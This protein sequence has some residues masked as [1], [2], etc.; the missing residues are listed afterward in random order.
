MN[1]YDVVIVG[2]GPG[3]YVAAIRSGQLGLR[4][5]LVERENVGGVCLNWGCVPTKALLRNA[6]VLNLFHRAKEFGIAVDSLQADYGKGVDRSRRVVKRLTTGVRA[7]LKK[8]GV[9]VIE[10]TGRLRSAD[11]LVVEP[12]GRSLR[13]ADII[14]A[15]GARP[16]ALPGIPVDGER[17]VTYRQ[18]IVDRSVP[19]S[20]V[21]VG[22]GPIGMEFAEVYHAYG[23]QV[24]VVEMLPHLLPLEDEEISETMERAFRKKGV[25]FRTGARVE[26]VVPEGDNLVVH[27]AG[28]AGDERLTVARVLVA[29]GIQ[30]NSEEIGLD[31]AGVQTE[32]GFIQ[33]NG[34][35]RT[36]V[37][38]VY[39][40]GDVTGKLPLAHVAMAQGVLAAEVIAGRSPVS[41]NYN[42]IPRCTYTSPQVASM[43][44]SEAQAREQGRDVAVGRFPFRA[45]GKALAL[46]DYEGFAKI[47]SD[48]HYGEILG[49]HLIGPEVTEMLPEFGLA[50]QLEAT[51]AEIARVVHAHPTLSEV[52]ME[53]ALDVEGAAIHK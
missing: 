36:N 50:V 22:A 47:V 7:L 13:A 15:T 23:S 26:A 5:A 31:R 49:V 29:I 45:N 20:I 17:I 24:T 14:I 28:D 25:A 35:M 2:G 41:L 34:Q 37:P 1:E 16:R 11:T 39:A 40:I 46:N 9:E 10:G 53:A 32:R 6:E 30:P 51:P 42:A 27:I 48:S 43:G 33:V 21:I 4:T 19:E 52:L 3:G 38:H 12:D 18:A 8:N 44:L